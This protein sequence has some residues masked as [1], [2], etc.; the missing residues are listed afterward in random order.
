MN[1]KPV[2]NTE[3]LKIEKTEELL[4]W[5]SGTPNEIIEQVRE[6]KEKYSHLTDLTIDY[7]WTGY[8][9]CE[10]NITGFLLESEEDYKERVQEEKEALQLWEYEEAVRLEQV[11][12]E[13]EAKKQAH[14][15]SQLVQYKVLQAALKKEGVIE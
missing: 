8:E 4:N 1:K 9:D 3:R 5:L 11:R 6:I 15:A 2:V 10:Y 7:Q 12:V 14:I 13:R